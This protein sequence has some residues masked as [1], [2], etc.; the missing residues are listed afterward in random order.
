MTGEDRMRSMTAG[1]VLGLGFGLV[2]AASCAT[3][4]RSPPSGA[5]S[6]P[7]AG[8]GPGAAPTVDWM[9]MARSERRDYMRTVVMPK[10][11][12]LFVAYDPARYGKMSCGTCHGDGAED[13]TFKMPNPKLPR[14]PPSPEG[15]KQLIAAKPAACQFM[16]VKL[17]PTMAALLGMPVFDPDTRTGFGCFNCHPR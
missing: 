9:G 4:P 10:A 14:L 11:K 12:E 16:L 3:P 8:A 5:G 1:N 17:K 6:P 13:G 7:P 2:W 15:F